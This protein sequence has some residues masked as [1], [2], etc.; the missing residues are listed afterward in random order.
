M[1]IEGVCGRLAVEYHEC[2][3]ITIH[4]SI[5]TTLQWVATV[6]RLIH[7]EFA[8]LG[9]HPTLRIEGSG[10]TAGNIWVQPVG[11]DFRYS[12]VVQPSG[13]GLVYSEPSYRQVEWTPMLAN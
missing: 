12:P 9:I 4:D 5:L 2:P 1:L 6:Q 3:V 10:V 13:Q 11:R 7:E 8:K